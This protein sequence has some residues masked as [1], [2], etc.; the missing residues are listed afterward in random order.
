MCYQPWESYIHSPT[1]ACA[2][3]ASVKESKNTA[4]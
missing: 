4:A 2:N 1:N 3:D